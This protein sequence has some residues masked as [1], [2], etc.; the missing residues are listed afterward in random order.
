MTLFSLIWV[1]SIFSDEYKSNKNSGGLLK[2]RIDSLS[3]FMLQRSMNLDSNVHSISEYF[4]L[5]NSNNK[6]LSKNDSIQD[7]F[8]YMYS[9]T[10]VDSMNVG[11]VCISLMKYYLHDYDS[12]RYFIEHNFNA[13]SKYNNYMLGI[14]SVENGNQREAVEYFENEARLTNGYKSKSYEYLIKYYQSEK[15]YDKLLEIFSEPSLNKYIDS[16]LAMD[17]YYLSGSF[18][19]YYK[20]IFQILSIRV[21]VVGVIAAILIMLVWIYYLLSINLFDKV[22]IMNIIMVQMAAMIFIFMVFP[23]SDYNKLILGNELKR[24]LLE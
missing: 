12:S 5:A 14:I 15:D 19:N 21:N 11:K 20:S 2:N 10:N 22:P 23:I 1:N 6:W 9:S 16:Y 17:L 7:T 24:R 13:E 18:L 4:S 8:R 3:N